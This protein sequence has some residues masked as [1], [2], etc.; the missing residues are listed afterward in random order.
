VDKEICFKEE[1][2]EIYHDKEI[3][4]Q[5]KKWGTM[6]PPRQAS[7]PSSRQAEVFHRAKLSLLPEA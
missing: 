4:W 2:V 5:K 3:Y 7:K 1:L 6:D